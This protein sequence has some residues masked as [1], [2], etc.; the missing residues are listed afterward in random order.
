MTDNFNIGKKN[1][2]YDYLKLFNRSMCFYLIFEFWGVL[3]FKTYEILFSEKSVK[4]LFCVL[5]FKTSLYLMYIVYYI[6]IGHKVK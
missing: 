3:L 1:I 4:S 2:F 6:E 5:L